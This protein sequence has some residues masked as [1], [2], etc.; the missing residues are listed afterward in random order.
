MSYMEKDVWSV[1]HIKTK[2]VKKSPSPK[3]AAYPATEILEP[4]VRPVDWLKILALEFYPR[5]LL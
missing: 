5:N 1:G 3:K 2:S 4:I